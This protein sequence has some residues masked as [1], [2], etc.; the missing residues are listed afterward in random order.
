MNE[1]LDASRLKI[2]VDQTKTFHVNS[3]CRLVWRKPRN[4]L[5]GYEKSICDTFSRFAQYL[6]LT[7]GKYIYGWIG[8]MALSRELLRDAIIVYFTVGGRTIGKVSC[9]TRRRSDT[10]ETVW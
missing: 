9:R 7:D 2:S 4:Q 6:L 3:K 5:P 1:S 10:G 8:C